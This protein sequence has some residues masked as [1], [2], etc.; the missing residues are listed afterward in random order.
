ME[1]IYRVILDRAERGM[2]DLLLTI[3]DAAYCAGAGLANE[4]TD[5]NV[6]DLIATLAT[7]H[8]DELL[9][10]RAWGDPKLARDDVPSWLLRQQQQADRPQLLAETERQVALGDAQPPP[11]GWGL[12][13]VEGWPI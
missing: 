6:R 5:P 10:M 7:R 1:T 11:E 4:T 2:A 8:H 9:A 3:Y 12:V 13:P